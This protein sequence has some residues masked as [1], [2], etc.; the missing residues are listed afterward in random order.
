[1]KVRAILTVP[2]GQAEKSEKTLQSVIFG[3]TGSKLTSLVTHI[4][5]DDSKIYWEAEGSIKDILKINR[6]LAM[7]DN[8]VR[9][10]LK[11]KMV[12]KT[13][14]SK[15][16]EQD[17]SELELMLTQQTSI[18]VVK[19]ATA[20]ELVEHNMTLWQKLTSKLKRLV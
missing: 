6:N 4:N 16:S 9:M 17:K 20:S 14:A 2:K 12:Q 7:Y 15:L 19:E 3:M 10:L 11:N 1:M 5:E 8:F 13:L 18:E